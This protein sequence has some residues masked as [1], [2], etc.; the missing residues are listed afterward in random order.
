MIFSSLFPFLDRH[1]QKR[2][3]QKSKLDVQWSEVRQV[4]LKDL[5]PYELILS[6]L[7]P[8]CKDYICKSLF[9]V[10]ILGFVSIR[11]SYSSKDL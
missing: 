3:L 1:V 6:Q 4:R 10:I 9:T 5:N 11:L 8:F 2:W 7:K